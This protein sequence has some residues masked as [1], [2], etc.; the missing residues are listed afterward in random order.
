LLDLSSLSP[1]PCPYNWFFLFS[2]A[3]IDFYLMYVCIAVLT[4][5]ESFTAGSYSA[6]A[7]PD[8]SSSL[9][10]SICS[11]WP[12]TL[13]LNT[14]RHALH[15]FEFSK[16]PIETLMVCMCSL[17]C[18]FSQYS[19]R[20]ETPIVS[21]D[22]EQHNLTIVC[23]LTFDSSLKTLWMSSNDLGFSSTMHYEV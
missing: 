12:T 16:R 15:T 1:K 4:C 3:N 5:V 17:L 14:G 18:S 2:T 20:L 19:L 13:L 11:G 22:C 21:C 8:M 6:L 9:Q 7:D 10:A 23:S